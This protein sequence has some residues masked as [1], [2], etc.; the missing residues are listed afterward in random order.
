MGERIIL[1][2]IGVYLDNHDARRKD[3]IGFVATVIVI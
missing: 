2:T 3:K 1:G